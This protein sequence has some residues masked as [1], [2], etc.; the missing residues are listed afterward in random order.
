MLTDAWP[1]GNVTLV[2]NPPDNNVGWLVEDGVKNRHTAEFDGD[3]DHFAVDAHVAYNLST[4]MT[5]AAWVKLADETPDQKI[6][7]QLLLSG[8]ANRGY[9]LGVLDG[10]VKAEVFDATGVQHTAEGGA[11]V[12]GTWTHLAATW[13]SGGQFIAYIDGRPV[14]T[15]TASAQPI[16]SGCEAG[17]GGCNVVIGAAPWNP[18]TLNVDGHIDEVLIFDKA[19]TAD[20]IALLA[21]RTFIVAATAESIATC[22]GNN[23]TLKTAIEQANAAA[24]GALRD[25]IHFDLPE[26]AAIT[27]TAALPEITD[28]AIVDGLT[29]PG[30]SC[31]AWP[32]TLKVALD[33][34]SAGPF[35][36]GLVIV[37]DAVT[38]RGLNVR[39]FVQGGIRVIDADDGLIECNLIGT[40]LAGATAQPN[41]SGIRLVGQNNPAL[42]HQ[43]V[44][45]LISGNMEDGVVILNSTENSIR[46]NYIGTGADGLTSLANGRHGIG[47][48][49]DAS[50]NTIGGQSAGNTIAFNG[51][52]GIL[53]F[54][55]TGNWIAE[56][57]IHHNA[58]SGIDLGDAV[59]VDGDSVTANDPGDVD[60]G[61][62]NLQN[63]PVL[64]GAVSG[65]AAT[66]V[67]GTLNS[68]ANT[69]FLIEFF[70]NPAADADGTC[71]GKSFVGFVQVATDASGN[72]S[73]DKT[74]A[75]T[76]PP[77]YRL[78][79]T[80]TNL[81]TFDTSE[82]SACA[83]VTALSPAVNLT[84]FERNVGEGRGGGESERC[85]ARRPDQRDPRDS[86]H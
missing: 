46:L 71:E 44:R 25:R 55:S 42:R 60:V 70:A 85:R 6:V 27:P 18:N 2:Q 80:A 16:G 50:T 43:V 39:N 7:G 19:L 83:P 69:Q 26:P 53:V 17:N 49:E 30:A 15:T 12:D 66:Q 72:A 24:N 58:G 74:L 1:Q 51:G 56:N 4:E 61:P 35:S 9:V 47:I 10:Q 59:T 11:M 45:N 31:A 76:L 82:F 52:D 48:Y 54:D 75:T 23:C 37:S 86:D 3:G 21:Q 62:N 32:P 29:Q 64:A 22:A 81:S 73:V 40:D 77:G 67:S 79:A 5:L 36:N 33:G 13:Q 34:S 20:A 41:H 84:P 78:S 28:A 63:Y 14:V 38:V 8:P 57:G 68:T 65:G